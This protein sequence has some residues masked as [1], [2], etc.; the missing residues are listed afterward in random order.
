MLTQTSS[1]KVYMYLFIIIYNA[2]FKKDDSMHL[3]HNPDS[4]DQIKKT[5]LTVNS[6][7]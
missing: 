4:L 3:K 7:K 6:N 2:I 5:F 1:N